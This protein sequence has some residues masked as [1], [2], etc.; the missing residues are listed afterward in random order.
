MPVNTSARTAALRSNHSRA[1]A[2]ASACAIAFACACAHDGPASDSVGSSDDTG[3][4]LGSTTSPAPTTGGDAPDTTDSQDTGSSSAASSDGTTGGENATLLDTLHARL[5]GDR[6]GSCIAAAVIDGGDVEHAFV[7]AARPPLPEATAFEIG[8]VSKTMTGFLVARAVEQGTMALEAPIATHLPPDA[9]VP[10]YGDQDITVAHLLTHTSGLPTVPASWIPDMDPSDPYAH[11]DDAR[12]LEALAD[13][14]LTQAPGSSWAYSNFGYMTLSFAVARVFE[15]GLESALHDE[16]FA[17][18][19]MS[20]FLEPPPSAELATPHLSNG[21]PTP[22]WTFAPDLAGVGGVRA[23]LDDMTRYV[24]AVL[25]DAPRELASTFA[26]ATAEL[27]HDPPAMAM[28]WVLLDIGGRQV[29]AHD[30]GTGGSSAIVLVDRE[31]ARAVVLLC[32]TSWGTIG[33]LAELSFHLLDPSL[34][35]LD[36]PRVEEL[37]PPDLVSALVG[38]YSIPALG[39]QIELRLDGD[40]LAAVVDGGDALPLGFDSYGDFFT[41]GDVDAVLRPMLD[42]DGQQTFALLT[43]EG[44]LPAVRL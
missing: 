40:T 14:E 15:V 8:S 26:L 33:G 23:S 35:A 31:D 2:R 42:D 4:D 41:R 25:G 5:D 39:L 24:Q 16:L 28:G 3:D 9:A 11:V 22:T 36:P 19:G 18:L 1:S 21:T 10:A 7:C 6:T 44:P 17:P 13:T 12:L 38:T 37:P 43:S 32:D 34:V 30:G 29:L 20:A 27:R